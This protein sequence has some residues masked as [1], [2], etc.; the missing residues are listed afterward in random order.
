MTIVLKDKLA[1]GVARRGKDTEIGSS[2][3]G[4]HSL[5][6]Q[7]CKVDEKVFLPRHICR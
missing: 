4:I 7:W 6:H 2:W 3:Y 5:L 1:K